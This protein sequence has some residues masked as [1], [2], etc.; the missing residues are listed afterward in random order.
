MGFYQIVP[1]RRSRLPLPV[2]TKVKM[3]PHEH[4]VVFDERARKVTI[5]RIMPDGSEHLYT[6]AGFPSESFEENKEKW[7]EFARLLGENLMLDSPSARKCMG[8]E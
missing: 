6:G 8:I 4:R 7:Q 3:K 1:A 5:Y 2:S